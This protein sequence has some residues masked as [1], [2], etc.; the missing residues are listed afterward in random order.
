M[1]RCLFQPAHQHAQRLRFLHN[2]ILRN[3]NQG[4]VGSV[5]RLQRAVKVQDAILMPLAISPPAT[6]VSYGRKRL[7]SILQE[8]RGYGHDLR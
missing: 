2:A 3:K 8:K 7:I 1:L 6:A 4:K 5:R